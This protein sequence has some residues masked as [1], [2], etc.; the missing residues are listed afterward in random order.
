MGRCTL[1]LPVKRIIAVNLHTDAIVIM[2]GVTAAKPHIFKIDDPPFAVNV[3]GR[4]G[5]HDSL[6]S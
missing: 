5:G 1:K 2:A 6:P 4:L 3:L